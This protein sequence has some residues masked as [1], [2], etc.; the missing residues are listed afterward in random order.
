MDRLY[1]APS[2]DPVKSIIGIIKYAKQ[3]ED[4]ADFLHCDIMDGKFVP[5]KTY[6][7]V[8]LKDIKSNTLLPLDAHLMIEKPTKFIDKFIKA[9]ANI[10]TVHYES[11][12][13]KKQLI[14]DLQ[15]IHNSGKLSGLSIKPLTNVTEILDL[16]AYCDLVLVMSVEPGKSGQKFLES[17]YGKVSALKKVKEDNNAHF[18]IEVDGGVNPEI[19]QKLKTLGADIVVSGNY[20]FQSENREEAIKLLR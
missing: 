5:S 3:V 11:Y 4:F 7:Y 15:Y 10:V 18:K 1:V 14:K 13:N 20:V 9:G 17:A 12:K 2:T 19:A 6:S 16:L 8:A